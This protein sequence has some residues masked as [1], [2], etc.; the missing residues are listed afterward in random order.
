MRSGQ[1]DRCR[2]DGAEE[3]A[4]AHF[5]HAGNR[6]KAVIAQRLLRVRRCRAVGLS[7]RCLAVALVTFAGGL[8]WGRE[9]GFI[10]KP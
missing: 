3:R 7:I 2:D 1:D 6:A 10:S 9:P 4:A 5:V 8:G